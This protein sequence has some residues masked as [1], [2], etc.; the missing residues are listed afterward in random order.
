MVAAIL[1]NV[2]DNLREGGHF[3][4]YQ[5]SLKNYDDVKPVFRNSRL[6]FTL[7]N[8]PPAFIYECTK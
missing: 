2:S 3:M 6:R 4:Q 5:Y 7:R 8:M 1:E